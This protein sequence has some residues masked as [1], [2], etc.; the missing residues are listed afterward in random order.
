MRPKTQFCG[1]YQFRLRNCLKCLLTGCWYLD[2][3]FSSAIARFAAVQ[4]SN[5]GQSPTSGQ[6]RAL[7]GAFGFRRATP[8]LSW[9]LVASARYTSIRPRHSL[10]LLHQI[11]CF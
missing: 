7:A 3:Q 5:S 1:G 9:S 4:V 8:I 2:L 11:I 6:P 10:L